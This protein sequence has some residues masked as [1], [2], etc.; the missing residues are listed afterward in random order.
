[1]DPRL[2]SLYEQELRYFRE[3]SS[4][5]ARAFPKIAHRLAQRLLGQRALVVALALLVRRMVDEAV[6]QRR[7]QPLLRS[8][9]SHRRRP[10]QACRPPRRRWWPA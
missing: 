8:E 10:R 2:L 3:S 7:L 5:F 1:M 9:F 4:E 6:E